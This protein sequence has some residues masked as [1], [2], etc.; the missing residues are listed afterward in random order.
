MSDALAPVTRRPSAVVAVLLTTLLTA[1][2]GAVD[3]AA[4][5]AEPTRDRATA[6]ATATPTGPAVPT[7]PGY[8]P[9]E[10]PPVPMILLP[11]LSMLDASLAG[12]AIE[13]DAAV[14]DLPGV[15]V[16]PQRCDAQ[17]GELWAYGD[18]SGTFTGPD[19][20][21]TTYGDGSGTY[22]LN[23]TSVT[24]YGDGSGTYDDGTTSVTSYGDGS[25]TYDDGTTSV[26]LYGDGS[27]TWSRGDR[28]ITN[29]G[30]GS[31]TYTAG[32]VTITHYGDG[33]GLYDSPDL[34]VENHGDGTGLVGTVPVRVEPLAP[35]PPLGVFPSMGVIGP[36]PSCGTRLVLDAA[37]LFDFDSAQVRPDAAA[38]LDAVAQ[39][40]ADVPTARVEGHTDAIASDAYNQDL[41]ERRAAAVAAALTQRGMRGALEPVGFGETR[42][43]APNT[44]D[45]ADDPAG[46]QLNRR[47][48][49]VVPS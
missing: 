33:S 21:V 18:G 34:T 31:G 16:Q 27:G 9:G 48:E 4:P 41:S 24:V 49:I 25:G 7:V 45:G 8:G 12:F 2:S 5:S 19:G 22:T 26:T 32:D 47:V 40:L 37:V 3:T 43:V 13:V 14:G 46:R 38:T 20:A 1:C 36:A 28:T 35:V 15:R 29:Y 6:R 23:G 39:V 11:D 10:V 17:G 30:D 44:R 42:P